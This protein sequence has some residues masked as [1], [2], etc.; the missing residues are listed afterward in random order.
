MNIDKIDWLSN[1]DFAGDLD[2]QRTAR[3]FALRLGN[4]TGS[5]VG[6]IFV[7]S[8]TKGEIFGATAKTYMRKIRAQRQM[9]PEVVA[10]SE[11][12]LYYLDYCDT[13]TKAMRWGTEHEQEARDL[14]ASTCACANELEVVE[15][16][17]MQLAGLDNFSSSPDGLILNNGEAVGCLEIKCPS[18]EVFQLYKDTVKDDPNDVDAAAE[19]LKKTKPLYYWQCQSHLLVTKALWCAFIVYCPFQREPLHVVHIWRNE[20]VLN[21][22]TERIKLANDWIDGND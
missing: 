17:A 8:R 12:F 13:T 19:A 20:K 2:A 9:N 6:N 4:I 14:Y 15:A 1:P 3:W 22:L 11:K 7:G 16:S 21:E 18:Q 5:E 10:D